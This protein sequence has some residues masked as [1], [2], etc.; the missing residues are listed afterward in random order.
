MDVAGIKGDHEKKVEVCGS[1]MQMEAAVVPARL[2]ILSVVE[3][4]D[5]VI[6]SD[7]VCLGWVF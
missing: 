6:C 4:V 3:S 5:R 1:R 7:S 2:S